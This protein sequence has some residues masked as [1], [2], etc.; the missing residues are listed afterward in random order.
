M[1]KLGGGILCSK[2][3]KGWTDCVGLIA[4]VLRFDEY[5][6]KPSTARMVF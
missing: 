5:C 1:S 3:L 4:G 2:A 6:A